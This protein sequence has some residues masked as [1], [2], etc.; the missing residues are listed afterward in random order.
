MSTLLFFSQIENHNINQIHLSLIPMLPPNMPRQSSLLSDSSLLQRG[1]HQR[2]FKKVIILL[3]SSP[4][5]LSLSN[6]LHLTIC[7]VFRLFGWKQGVVL[8][9][10]IAATMHNQPHCV[11]FFFFFCISWFTRIVVVQRN[12]MH[13]QGRSLTL[14]GKL[15]MLFSDAW[16]YTT[17]NLAFSSLDIFLSEVEKEIWFWFVNAWE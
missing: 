3:S 13:L 2:H 15:K 14:N 17:L 16:H 12:L 6:S 4:S 5:S 11:R 8:F 1:H 10:A 9:A 7:V